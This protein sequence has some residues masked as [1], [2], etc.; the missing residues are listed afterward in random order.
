MTIVLTVSLLTISYYFSD[1]IIRRPVPNTTSRYGMFN[2]VVYDVFIKGEDD[3][4]DKATGL[5]GMSR[6]GD[7]PKAMEEFTQKG[8]E[9]R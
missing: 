6:F 1:L 5:R 8:L 2:H 3:F 7:G 4:E 9:F